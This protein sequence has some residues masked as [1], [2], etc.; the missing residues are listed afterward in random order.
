M[1]IM[2]DYMEVIL[3]IS[4]ALEQPTAD[5]MD[6]MDRPIQ[7]WAT[8]TWVTLGQATVD[9]A[10]VGQVTADMEFPEYIRV[11]A[12]TEIWRA[13]VVTTAVLAYTVRTITGVELKQEVAS[14][15][16]GETRPWIRNA[17]VSFNRT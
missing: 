13:M 15:R 3:D 16:K 14:S 12:P 1:Y 6:T 4:T 5:I 2:V 7:D 10:T 17:S 9:Q 8:A 11:T